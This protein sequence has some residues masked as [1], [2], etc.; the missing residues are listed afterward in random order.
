[1][2]WCRL[3][4][5]VFPRPVP[6]AADNWSVSAAGFMDCPAVKSRPMA[7]KAPKGVVCLPL[8]LRF[9]GLT[10]QASFEVWLAIENK[11]IAPKLDY[12][13]L[14]IDRFSGGALTDGVPDISPRQTAK[15]TLTASR[16][17]WI[18]ASYRSLATT[19]TRGKPEGRLGRAMIH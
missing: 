3:E 13:P 9:H 10:T 1:M 18:S 14:R 6:Y 19:G 16:A 7:R 8:A 15:L 17:I 12:P 4:F 2:T 11:A 5:P